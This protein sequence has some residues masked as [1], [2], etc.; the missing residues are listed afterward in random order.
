MG[1]FKKNKGSWVDVKGCTWK[2][3]AVSVTWKWKRR[4]HKTMVLE[5]WWS[6]WFVVSAVFHQG[7]ILLTFTIG[8]GGGGGTILGHLILHFCSHFW[9]SVMC[10]LRKTNVNVIFFCTVPVVWW[11]SAVFACM[12]GAFTHLCI[13]RTVEAKPFV[14]LSEVELFVLCWWFVLFWAKPWESILKPVLVSKLIWNVVCF[15]T[16]L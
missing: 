5:H 3:V 8:G 10:M 16:I 14:V 1:W 9:Q 2:W 6:L 15:K 13:W 4:V 11:L 7:F 12:P